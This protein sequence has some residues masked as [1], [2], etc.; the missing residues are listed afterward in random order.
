LFHYREDHHFQFTIPC[1]FDI[2]KDHFNYIRGRK[3]VPANL[4][5]EG[6][7]SLVDLIDAAIAKGE[8]QTAE[9][10]LSLEAGHGR[11]SGGWQID[12]CTFPWKENTS[13]MLTEVRVEGEKLE[14]AK[15]LVMGEVWTL[16][17]S[18]FVG[19]D[20]LQAFFKS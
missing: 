17:D 5:Y 13:L 4:L 15:I 9:K 1:S 19:V 8:R 6:S 20:G 16:F 7:T 14:T 10:Y 3:N 18:S 11:V 2:Q 12:A